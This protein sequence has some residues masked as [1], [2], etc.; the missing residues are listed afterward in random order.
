MARW[1]SLV[2]VLLLSACGEEGP[3]VGTYEVGGTW[4]LNGPLSGGKS[5]GEATAELFVDEV[6]GALPAPDTVI[7]QLAFGLKPR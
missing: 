1:T 4:K 7:P 3:W 6:S 5:V 2:V